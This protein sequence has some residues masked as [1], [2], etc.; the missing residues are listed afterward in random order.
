MYPQL[1]PHLLSTKSLHSAFQLPIIGR[2]SYWAVLP[3][4]LRVSWIRYDIGELQTR[5]IMDRATGDPGYS[6]IVRIGYPSHYVLTLSIHLELHPRRDAPNFLTHRPTYI[7][8]RS[9]PQL[10]LVAPY[11]QYEG[12]RPRQ[13]L[14]LSLIV[15]YD[16]S[17][18][19]CRF[20]GHLTRCH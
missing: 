13:K 9:G 1:V 2:N 18:S 17:V 15:D 12:H 8:A 3:E 5:I 16:H 19:R 14:H 10:P 20:L 4:C 7:S 6:L 11:L